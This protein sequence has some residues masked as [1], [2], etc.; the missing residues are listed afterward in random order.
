MFLMCIIN[1]GDKLVYK[2]KIH[3]MISNSTNML[4]IYQS[5][6]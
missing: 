2:E 3:T 5:N 4:E 6:S 1:N